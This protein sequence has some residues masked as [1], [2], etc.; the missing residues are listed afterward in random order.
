MSFRLEMWSERCE[1]MCS[2]RVAEILLP[3]GS[4]ALRKF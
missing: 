3:F 1:E 2:L 4:G